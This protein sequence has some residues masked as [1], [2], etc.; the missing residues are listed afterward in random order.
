MSTNSIKD[1]DTLWQ[2][3]RK[4]YLANGKIDLIAKIM[5]S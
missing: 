2:L 3:N 4:K 1:S 5:D